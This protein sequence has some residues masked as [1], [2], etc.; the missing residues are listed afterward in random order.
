M[1]L[2]I[3]LI[4]FVNINLYG[5]VDYYDIPCIEIEKNTDQDINL[6]YLLYY[7]KKYDLF[8]LS[9]PHVRTEIDFPYIKLTPEKDFTGFTILTLKLAVN[10]DYQII[11]I[12]VIAQQNLFPV[13]FHYKSRD[14]TLNLYVAGS[15]NNWNS[16]KDRMIYDD[17]NEEYFS[18]LEM[19]QGVYYYKFVKNN[20]WEYDN[21]N[22]SRSPDGFGSYNSI[23]KVG[24]SSRPYIDIVPLKKYHFY[25]DSPKKTRINKKDIHV[26]VNNRSFDDFDLKHNILKL[27]YKKDPDSLK[28][29]I[30]KKGFQTTRYIDIKSYVEWQKR[31]MYFAFTDRF[32][33]GN[34]ENDRKNRPDYVDPICDY[35]GGD[36]QGITQKIKEGYFKTLGVDVLWISPVNDNPEEYYRDHFPPHKYF[37][38]YHGYWPISPE[39]VENH[40]GTEDDLQ[41]LVKTA[42]SNNIKIMFD[43]VL[44]H[45]HTN[46]PFH[47]KDPDWYG[48]VYTPDG[49]LNLRLFDEFPFTTWFDL[50]LPSFDYESDF[51]QNAMVENT[52][53]WCQQFNIDGFRLDA[54]KHIP[55]KFWKNLRLLIRRQIEFREKKIFYMVGESISDRETINRFIGYDQLDGQFDFPLYFSIKE[56]LAT[57]RG[58]FIALNND[59]IDSM[60]MY[61]GLMSA[62]LG[63]HDF[64][65]FMAYADGDLPPGSD[66]RKIGFTY[67]IKVDHRDSY[68]KI[69]KA[70]LIILTLSEIPLIY[71]GDEIGMTGA[72]DPDNRRMLKFE[73]DPPEQELFNFVSGLNHLRKRFSSL[74]KGLYYPLKVEKDHL[75]YLK[76]DYDDIFMIGV[77]K[78]EI[79]EMTIEFPSWLGIKRIKDVIK[80]LNI[81]VKDNK[82]KVKDFNYFIYQVLP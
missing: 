7:E 45:T 15:F 38:G 19:R 48:S 81:D 1:V 39:K 77:S 46:H 68:E 17:D 75:V 27:K 31:V 28:V 58:D 51:V 18:D 22:P 64:P 41:N 66:E 13:R 60:R 42:H 33:N 2:F 4:L 14:K 61:K 34:K 80:K 35:M 21:N 53:W 10:D 24:E 44:N 8:A 12:P 11:E 50:F 54:V 72:A 26:F 23:L 47:K 57:G 63:N 36:F 74:Y 49:R 56:V 79:K 32:C 82:I 6:D 52:L 16:Q 76:I 5:Q 67:S 65:R 25:L 62:F 78:D 69:K 30:T 37:S 70:F 71:Y 73:L 40:F 55:V 59:I 29:F 9:S 3:L 20:N 43:M